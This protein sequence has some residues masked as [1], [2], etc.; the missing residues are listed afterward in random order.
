[1]KKSILSIVAITVL[2]TSSFAEE[3][4]SQMVTAGMGMTSYSYD[5]YSFDY[6]IVDLG[7]NIGWDSYYI[8]INAMLPVSE[9][10]GPY[11]GRSMLF[12]RSQYSFNLAYRL[13]DMGVALF[14]GVN[15]ANNLRE[16]ASTSYTDS[17]A[18][19]HF[20]IAGAIYSFESLGTLTGK[21]AFSTSLLGYDTG[22][23]ILSEAGIGYLFGLGLVGPLFDEITYN[24]NLDMYSYTYDETAELS[25]TTTT[26]TTLK[27][28]IG[29]MF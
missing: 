1:M 3:A 14:T 22:T 21:A 19:F 7:Y 6:S 29:Y 18:G 2:A 25:K 28:G 27:A 5:E 16:D 10:E 13:E 15:Y 26:S 8:N 23:E 11:Y 4:I 24:I 17:E 20:G 9:A 12:Q